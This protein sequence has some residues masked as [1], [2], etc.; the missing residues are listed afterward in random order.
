MII[1]TRYYRD[2]VEIWEWSAGTTRRTTVPYAPS[3]YLH[4]PDPALHRELLESLEAEYGAEECTFRTIF[5]E[6]DGYRIPAGREIAEAIERQTG[7]AAQLYNVDVR[8]DQRY[9]AG[10][11]QV[12]V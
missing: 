9:L 2:G 12:P 7:Y 6:C 8:L 4:L 1:D 5:G 11:G 3:F 10:V